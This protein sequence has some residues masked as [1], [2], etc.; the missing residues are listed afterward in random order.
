[1]RKILLLVFCA[2]IATQLNGQL[3]V[4][5]QIPT[6]GLSTKPQL[7]NMVLVNT[8]S[9]SLQ[10]RVNLLFTDITN[11]QAVLTA[12]S[13]LFSL[14][15]GTH[16]LQ[17]NNFLPIT[18]NVVNS[19][20][21][22][23]SDPNGFLPIGHFSVC[24][25]FEKFVSDFYEQ[26]AEECETVEIEPVSPPLLVYP[27]DEAMLET[28]RPVFTWLPPAP[29]TYFSSLSYDIR[30]VE[31][32]GN[33]SPEDAIQQ[34]IA[35]FTQ[36][37]IA[38]LV[39]AYPSSLSALDTGKLY[40]W[41]I[42]ANNNNSFVAKSDIW[43]FR[44]GYFGST[45]NS[46]NNGEP[47]ARLR[48]DGNINYFLCTGVLQ[49]EYDNYLNDDTVTLAVYDLGNNYAQMELDSNHLVLQHGQNLI[50]ADFS[51]NNSFQNDH[52]YQVELINSRREKWI[53]KFYFRRN[54]Q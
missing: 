35:I 6:I 16:A 8:G 23:T 41:Q 42:T 9:Q 21:N 51:E 27:E 17:T 13:G 24:Y 48:K 37:N 5:L 31:A 36:Q 1:M 22:I 11:N 12:T 43:T 44:I 29:M 39:T 38:N 49:F 10:V 7:W 32:I 26:I 14:S 4:N 30:L 25:Q 15:P 46:L 53:G 20:Y 2:I 19:N 40:A 47:F 28:S 45:G 18:Y 3:L 50:T 54:N 34:N 52:I 33:Q